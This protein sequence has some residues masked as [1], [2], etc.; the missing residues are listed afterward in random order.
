M[1]LSRYQCEELAQETFLRVWKH[2]ADFNP[3]K[4]SLRTWVYTIARNLALDE[5]SRKSNTVETEDIDDHIGNVPVASGQQPA[6][7]LEQYRNM[8]RLRKAINKLSPADRAVISTTYTDELSESEAAAIEGC[9]ENAL[10]ARLSRARQ[11]LQ[12][13][14]KE[15]DQS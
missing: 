15:D 14:L 1:G 10:R 2:K 7:V 12:Q 8:S 13:I 11:K 5:I 3:E 6:A 4:S 9:S